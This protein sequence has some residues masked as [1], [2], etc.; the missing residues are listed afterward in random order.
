M[1]SLRA[2]LIGKNEEDSAQFT[3][4]DVILRNNAVLMKISDV[5]DKTSAEQY[6]N[7]YVYVNETD[8][9]QPPKGAFF[10][11]E[12]IGCEVWDTDGNIVGTIEDVLKLPAQDVWSV[13]TK[14][15][16]FMLPAVKEFVRKVDLKSK[17]VVIRMMEGLVEE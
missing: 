10:V 5:D 9:Q 7:C 15:S 13:R 1:K 11:H 16:S 12:M 6:R 17:K 2:V 3:V 4:E 8:V 14:R